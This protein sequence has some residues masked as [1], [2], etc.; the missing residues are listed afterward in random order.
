MTLVGQ[1]RMHWPHLIQRERKSFSGSAPGG[2]TTAGFQLDPRDPLTRSIGITAA[3]EI[4]AVK[5]CRRDRS[6][7]RIS[8]VAEG[9]LRYVIESWRQLPR[10]FIH[11]THSLNLISVCGLQA[12]SQFFSQIRHWEQ[13][14]LILPI[15]HRAKRPNT[16]KSAPVGQINRQ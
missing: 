6:G 14:S 16:P 4:V 3:P 12:P 15:R 11:S 8:P 2:R 13:S 5:N 9:V 1:I 7:P 10:Q